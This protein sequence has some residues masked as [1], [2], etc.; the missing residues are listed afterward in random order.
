MVTE[1]VDVVIVAYRSD[2]VIVGA[3]GAAAKLGGTVVVVDH[4]DGRSAALAAEA[5][6]VTVVDPANP[7]FG[8]GQNHGVARTSSPYVLLCNPD[9]E[10]EVAAVQAGADYLELHPGVA[11]VQG[12]IVNRSTGAAERSQGRALGPVHLV[13]RALGARRLLRIPAI[14]RL[15]RRTATLRDH[16]D[17]VPAEPTEVESLAATVLLVR[18]AAFDAVGG[19]DPRYFLY[20]EDLDL[21]LRLRRAGWALTARPE[22]WAAHESGGSADSGVSRELHWWRGTMQYAARWWSFPGWA[23]A[24]LAGCLRAIRLSFS[25]P[26]HAALAWSFL[27]VAPLRA[28]LSGSGPD[29]AGR[30]RRVR[31]PS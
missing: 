2:E 8:T 4:G 11:A 28:R 20:G 23:V 6:A 12:V 16:A 31:R 25:S 3:V 29:G 1:A 7:G 5:G 24:V 22:V 21:C 9:A 15:A 30:R 14:R 10:I 13:G 27:V 18:R 19:F 26:A 17:R